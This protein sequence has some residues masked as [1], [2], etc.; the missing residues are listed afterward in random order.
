Q[1]RAAE[2][3]RRYEQARDV[4]D[5]L[6]RELLPGGVPVLPRLEVAA[7]YLLA[8]VETAAGGD[9]FD[10]LAFE[11]GRV[12]LG[13]GDVVGHGISASA[14]MGQLRVLL[15]ERLSATGDLLTALD[16]L[17]LAAR[18]IPGARAATVCVAVLDPTTGALSYCTA[19][20]PAPLLL[21]VDGE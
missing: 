13:G 20:H 10:A 18:W 21:P 2:V 14:T 11:D 17:N 16:A 5:A 4:I 3:Q 19:G 6:Q 15:R 7:S 8:D 9:W 1:A 12:A